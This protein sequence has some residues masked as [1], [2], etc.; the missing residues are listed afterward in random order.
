[1]GE[2]MTHCWRSL[3]DIFH[4]SSSL[5]LVMS[6]SMNGTESKEEHQEGEDGVPLFIFSHPESDLLD[7]LLWRHLS[8]FSPTSSYPS[9]SWSWQIL[10]MCLCLWHCH[11]QTH[12]SFLSLVWHPWWGWLLHFNFLN[13]VAV[14]L[15]WKGC[16]ISKKEEKKEKQS[17]AG[18]SQH[19]QPFFFFLNDLIYALLKESTVHPPNTY[20]FCKKSERGA[21]LLQSKCPDHVSCGFCFIAL[22]DEGIQDL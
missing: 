13:F 8:S 15:S 9:F 21:F 4:L 1:M 16:E 19:L 14:L 2:E 17:H 12:F 20:L 10:C 5:F 18:L 7:L 22:Q 3:E 11:L 6:S